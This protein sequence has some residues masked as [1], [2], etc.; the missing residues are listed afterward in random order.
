MVAC[1]RGTE[2]LANAYWR[3][4]RPQKCT[5]RNETA[6]T[7]MRSLQQPPAYVC[8]CKC[9]ANSGCNEITKAL[10]EICARVVQSVEQ[11]QN[12]TWPIRLW[13]LHRKIKETR[14]QVASIPCVSGCGCVCGCGHR[15]EYCCSALRMLG[16]PVAVVK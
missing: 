13:P 11:N 15:Y 9:R 1:P 12:R 16:C 14:Q 2:Y 8:V 5:M 7:T 3:I 6:A 10:K 4:C